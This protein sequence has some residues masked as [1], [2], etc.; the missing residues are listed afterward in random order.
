MINPLNSN[1]PRGGS[2][3]LLNIRR[4]SLEPCWRTRYLP[5][6]GQ[7]CPAMAADATTRG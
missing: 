2:G 1:Q 7:R 6:M 3:A 4:S 5:R